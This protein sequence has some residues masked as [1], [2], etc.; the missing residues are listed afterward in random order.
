MRYARMELNRRTPSGSDGNSSAPSMIVL[1]SQGL[2]FDTNRQGKMNR[3]QEIN[4]QRFFDQKGRVVHIICMKLF[5]VLIESTSQ[6]TVV[7]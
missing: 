1:E 4:F 2:K 3:W 6:C 7:L 5:I